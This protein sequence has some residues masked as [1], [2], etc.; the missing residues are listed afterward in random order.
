SLALINIPWGSYPSAVMSK[1]L[2][3]YYRFS[4]ASSGFGIATNQGRLGLAWN[5]TYEGGYASMDGPTNMSNFEPG[6]LAVNLD[7][8]TSDVS[9]PPLNVT[10]T[11]ATIAAWVYSGGG[12]PND[13]AIYFERGSSACGL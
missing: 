10:L 1:D 2:L 9:A 3:L 8:L 5:G 12:Q 11:N 6:N 13:S 7:G 4:D